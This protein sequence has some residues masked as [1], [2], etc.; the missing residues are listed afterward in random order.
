MNRGK[1][2][3]SRRQRAAKLKRIK[4]FPINSVTCAAVYLLDRLGIFMPKQDQINI[5]ETLILLGFRP[6]L[7]NFKAIAK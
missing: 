3:Q 2:N 5:A 4:R 6:K 1:F 7:L